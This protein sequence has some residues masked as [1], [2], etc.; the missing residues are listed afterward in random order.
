MQIQIDSLAQDT[1][2]LKLAMESKDAE[3]E[4]L[5]QAGSAKDAALDGCKEYV[6][7]LEKGRKWDKIKIRGLAISVPVAFIVAVVLVTR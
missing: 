5:K 2:D 6:A 3:A 1:A 7:T 4:N